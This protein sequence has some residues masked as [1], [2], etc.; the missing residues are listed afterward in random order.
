MVNIIKMMM[1]MIKFVTMMMMIRP[2]NRSVEALSKPHHPPPLSDLL[3]NPFVC[4][5]KWLF[6]YG[7]D[8]DENKLPV[9]LAC[10]ALKSPPLT[11]Q[12]HSEVHPGGETLTNYEPLIEPSV[13]P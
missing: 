11:S 1:M 4:N 3:L 13:N 10:I 9:K 7:V 8:D 2:A 5:G 6:C 12:A